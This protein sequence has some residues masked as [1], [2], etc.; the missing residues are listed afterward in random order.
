M[1]MQ[2]DTRTE[3]PIPPE[4]E[5]V[6]R[7]LVTAIRVVKLYPPNNPVYSQSVKKSLETLDH[8]LGSSPDYTFGVQKTGFTWEKSL[9]GKDA[10][11]NR[12]IAQDLFLKGLREVTISRDVSGGELLDLCRALALTSEEL[13]MRS[14]ISSVLWEQG[15]THIKVIEAGLDDVITADAEGGQV[16]KDK[17]G[18]ALK[19][20]RKATVFDGR[21][22]LLGDVTSNPEGFGASM[23]ELARQT[24]TGQESLE[25]RLHTL[26][27]QAGRKVAGEHPGRTDEM[28]DGLAKSVLAL[29]SPYRER[30]VAG[31]LYGDLD[32]ELS[33]GTGTDTEQQVPNLP[34]EV[35]TGRY[36]DTWTVQQIAT[37]LK[38]SAALP[39]VPPAP[40]PL[41]GDLPVQPVAPDLAGIAKDL[42][43]YRPEEMAALKATAEAGMES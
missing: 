16:A 28:F 43:D 37:L 2:K 21:T 1:N 17:A 42:A 6:M 12:T 4:I 36:A 38:R 40:L 29:E 35:Q 22:L 11:L 15:A 23:I 3:P 10:Q 7:N 30:L 32:A 31:K 26:Y 14:G 5:E 27:Q 20:E 8:Y 19:A 41:A 9:I 33:E 24:K 39:V 34:Q 13:S 25:D 18:G